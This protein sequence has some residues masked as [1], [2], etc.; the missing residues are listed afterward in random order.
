[1]KLDYP[2]QLVGVEYSADQVIAS[3]EEI[4]CTVTKIDD[5]VQVIVPSWRPDITHK[6]DL[7]EEVARLIG[8]R[9]NSGQTAGCTSGAWPYIKAET[10]TPGAIRTHRCWIRRGSELP[11]CIC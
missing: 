6:T 10:S 5:L 8:I 1:M 11:V 9:Q 7:V 2:G 3:L 4:G